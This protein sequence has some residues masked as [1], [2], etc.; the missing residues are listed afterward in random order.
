MDKR[1]QVRD[2][3]GGSRPV[4]IR[5]TENGHWIAETEAKHPQEWGRQKW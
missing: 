5:R 1:K 2:R 4:H 3:K